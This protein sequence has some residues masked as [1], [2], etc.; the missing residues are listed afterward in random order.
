[1]HIGII[2]DG[3]RR[4]AKTR[5]L[6]NRELI[7][8]WK[9]DMIINAYHKLTEYL[10]TGEM[11]TVRNLMEELSCVKEV[12]LYVLSSDNIRREDNTASIVYQLFSEL[13]MYF[14]NL[15]KIG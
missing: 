11:S 15:S 10:A 14:Q 9:H 3:N 8:Y 5:N 2:P 13:Q 12:S 6:N 7:D 1:M 4:W